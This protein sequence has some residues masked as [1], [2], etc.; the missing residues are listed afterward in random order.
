[1]AAEAL[2]LELEIGW[3]QEHIGNTFQTRYFRIWKVNWNSAKLQFRVALWL[4]SGLK[5]SVDR[6][7]EY[8]ELFWEFHKGVNICKRKHM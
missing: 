1:M 4:C 7:S 8:S 3:P 2:G 5:Y 6:L